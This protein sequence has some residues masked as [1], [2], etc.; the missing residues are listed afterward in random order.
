MTFKRNVEC[1]AARGLRDSAYSGHT[2]VLSVNWWPG[3]RREWRRILRSGGSVIGGDYG[4][5]F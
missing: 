5:S 4:R 2:R 1:P 3:G